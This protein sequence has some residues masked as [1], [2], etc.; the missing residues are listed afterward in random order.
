M[1]YVSRFRK[2]RQCGV[3][4]AIRRHSKTYSR[5]CTQ[6]AVATS[7][8]FINPLRRASIISIQCVFPTSQIIKSILLIVYTRCVKKATKTCL[9]PNLLSGYIIISSMR[10]HQQTPAPQTALFSGSI[11]LTQGLFSQRLVSR[12]INTKKTGSQGCAGKRLV[13]FTHFDPE[14]RRVVRWR[15]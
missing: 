12:V 9:M 1:V 11:V 3:L 10:Y 15:Y 4:D 2:M 13:F 8:S 7:F 6:W 5:H 14:L